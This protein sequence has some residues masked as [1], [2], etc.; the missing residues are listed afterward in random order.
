MEVCLYSEPD[1]GAMAGVPAPGNS[2]IARK[3]EYQADRADDGGYFYR[4]EFRTEKG[5][6]GV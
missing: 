2:E 4:R 5:R 3:E 6:P 1:G